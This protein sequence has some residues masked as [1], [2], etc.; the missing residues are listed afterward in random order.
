MPHDFK[1]LEIYLFIGAYA[2]FSACYGYLLF[3]GINSVKIRK[4]KSAPISAGNDHSV[5]LYIKHIRR[6]YVF[7][8]SEDIH[9]HFKPL[10]FMRS[11][12]I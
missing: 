7:R 3:H 11:K 2:G 12:T 6:I 1:S 9:I 10:K 5:S 4:Q 8:F